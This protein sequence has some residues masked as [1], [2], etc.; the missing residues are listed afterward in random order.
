MGGRRF[1]DFSNGDNWEGGAPPDSD[2][3]IT[4]GAVA[5]ARDAAAVGAT[6]QF[7]ITATVATLRIV[8]SATLNITSEGTTDLTIADLVVLLG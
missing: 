5:A 6:V 4:I 2:D 1:S 7:D 8:D 3:N